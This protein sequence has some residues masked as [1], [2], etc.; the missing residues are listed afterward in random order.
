MSVFEKERPNLKS[1]IAE[2]N[3]QLDSYVGGRKYLANTNYL[4]RHPLEYD[5]E[6]ANRLSRTTYSNK[7]KKYIDKTVN[8][9]YSKKITRTLLES[10]LP[11]F[12]FQDFNGNELEINSF[13]NFISKLRLALGEVYIYYN[14]PQTEGKTNAETKY[15]KI[16]VSPILPQVIKYVETYQGEIIELTMTVDQTILLDEKEIAIDQIYYNKNVIT[17]H[18]KEKKFN[19]K[20]EL[21]TPNNLGQV[22]FI[23]YTLDDNFDGV[24]DSYTIDVSR[25]SNEAHNIRSWINQI[26][27]DN[28]YPTMNMPMNESMIGILETQYG[29]TK[30]NGIDI[31]DFRKRRVQPHDSGN[32]I[33]YLVNDLNNIDKLLAY[34]DKL[35]TEITEAVSMRLK[36]IVQQSGVSKQ[37]DVQDEIQVLTFFSQEK[38]KTAEEK[39]WNTVLSLIGKEKLDYTINYPDQTAFDLIDRTQ[40]LDNLVL[41]RDTIESPKAKKAIDK[42]IVKDYLS[43]DISEDEI[44]IINKEIDDGDVVSNTNDSIYNESLN[45]ND[46]EVI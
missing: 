31:V 43:N 24:S 10:S 29:T 21:S 35:E 33:S 19:G 7:N 36:Q 5:E 26:L 41:I 14:P 45:I 20:N 9:V 6:Y 4:H 22:P 16:D 38:F 15:S 37:Y 18:F 44:N 39:F 40:R 30:K 13:F 12:R 42:I 3:F 32:S 2:W 23:Q 8:S 11:F 25:L 17:Y 1:L 34:E 28:M 27:F 46:E